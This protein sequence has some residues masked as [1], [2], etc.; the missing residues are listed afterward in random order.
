MLYLICS[1]FLKLACDH[2]A[3]K[4]LSIAFMLI[5]CCA[6]CPLSGVSAQILFATFVQ[7]RV[8]D[9]DAMLVTVFNMTQRKALEVQLQ[10][11]QITLQQ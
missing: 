7:D 1:S 8:T 10:E 11:Q 6:Q 5:L 3:S 4:L 9:S 2:S